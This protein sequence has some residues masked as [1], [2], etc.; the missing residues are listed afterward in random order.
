M[1]GGTGPRVTALDVACGAKSPSVAGWSRQGLQPCFSISIRRNSDLTAAQRNLRRITAGVTGACVVARASNPG[2]LPLNYSGWLPK[3]ES[4][5]RSRVDGEV[6]PASLPQMDLRS[7]PT[8]GRHRTENSAQ[9]DGNR[10]R[11]SV[12]YRHVLY[13]LSYEGTPVSLPQNG[14]VG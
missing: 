1:R 14:K 3:P 5:R 11:D 12:L 8:R 10:T 2:V 13:R 7:I 6:T 9:C 4:N